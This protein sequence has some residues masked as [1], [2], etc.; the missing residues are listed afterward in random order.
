VTHG[1]IAV[2]AWTA[3]QGGNSAERARSTLLL[4]LLRTRCRLRACRAV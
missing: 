4:L 1:R 2:R 3:V